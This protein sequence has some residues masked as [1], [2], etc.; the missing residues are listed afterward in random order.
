MV[1]LVHVGQQPPHDQAANLLPVLEVANSEGQLAEVEGFVAESAAG[2]YRE[3]LPHL[4]RPLL[5]AH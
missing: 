2:L 1:Q 3:D 4:Q 5:V